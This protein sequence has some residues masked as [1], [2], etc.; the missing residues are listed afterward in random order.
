MSNNKEVKRPDRKYWFR[1]VDDYPEHVR[2]NCYAILNH[3][4]TMF[5]DDVIRR[6]RINEYG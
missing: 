6:I 1:M 5:P 3:G 2:G 4:H